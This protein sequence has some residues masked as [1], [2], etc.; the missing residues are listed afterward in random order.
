MSITIIEAQ[1]TAALQ[2]VISD[3]CT[4]NNLTPLPWPIRWPNEGWSNLPAG[5]VESAENVLIK[6]PGGT[7]VP[8]VEA[9]VISGKET[10]L[11][12]PAGSRQSWT[13]G[14]FRVY[15]VVPLRSGR[16]AANILADAVKQA[17]KQATI[18]YDPPQRLYTLDARI[19]DNVAQHQ[20]QANVRIDGLVPAPWKGDRY[21]RMVSAPWYWDYIS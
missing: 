18:F 2:T 8:F 1:F 7:P 6:N 13:V 14:L 21:V 11:I 20:T 15:L 16:A 5:V 17:F 19:D 10:S 3:A 4:A 12:A 9:E